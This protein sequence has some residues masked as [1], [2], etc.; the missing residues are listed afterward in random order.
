MNT[1]T[2]LFIA[3]T[4]GGLAEFLI[5]HLVGDVCSHQ[6]THL[7]AQLLVN[8]LWDELQSV[9]SF[10]HPLNEPACTVMVCYLCQMW[11]SCDLR[12]QLSSFF[13]LSEK[14]NATEMTF[15]HTAY[16]FMS[17]QDLDEWHSKRVLFDFA[18]HGVTDTTDELMWNHKEQNV[19][20]LGSVEQI[21]H[22]HLWARER[23]EREWNREKG[24]CLILN[25]ETCRNIHLLN[26]FTIWLVAPK[27]P[28]DILPYIV[29][30]W[31]G[32][33]PFQAKTTLFT[34]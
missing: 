12:K 21:G 10:I 32:L 30:F 14:E 9:R 29:F 26:I 25:D 16:V 28:T 31:Q 22:R 34:L 4:N 23:R 18:L 8:D 6:H 11:W 3:L 1:L 33:C 5:R 2:S 13:M 15:T 19:S 24:I 17:V 7:N 20:A 27:V